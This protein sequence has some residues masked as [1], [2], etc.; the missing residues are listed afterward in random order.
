MTLEQVLIQEA[1][2]RAQRSGKA[3]EEALVS[4]KDNRAITVGVYECA[5]VMNV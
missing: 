2:E 5:K 4:A 3:L 1:E